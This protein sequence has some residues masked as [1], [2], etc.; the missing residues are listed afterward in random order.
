MIG[1]FSLHL[2][3]VGC[4]ILPKAELGI[5]PDFHLKPW[6]VDFALML[7]GLVCNFGSQLGFA[8][9]G[10]DKNYADSTK[11]HTNHS[12]GTHDIGPIRRLSLRYKIALFTLIFSIF[13]TLF[14]NAIRLIWFG[15]GEA[16]LPYLLLGVS[17]I[18]ATVIIGLPLVI[19]VSG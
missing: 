8:E 12:G 11:S 19:G 18:F 7:K 14:C 16:A 2:H 3:R 9:G 5:L 15:K 13:V 17:G 10:P 1:G 4:T 6:P